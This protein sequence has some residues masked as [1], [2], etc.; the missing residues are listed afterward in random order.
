MTEEQKIPYKESALEDKSRFERDMEGY[1]A[2]EASS[3]SESDNG[4]RRRRRKKDPNEPKRALSAYLF[5]GQEKR[6][7]VKQANP[8]AKQ[9]EIIRIL[10]AMWRNLSDEDKIPFNEKAA[11]DK[12]R[13]ARQKAQYDQEKQAKADPYDSESEGSSDEMSSEE[14]E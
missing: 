6:E 3:E 9:P 1:D 14:E 8:E 5:F 11:L 2:P 12:Q 10:G 4:R 7:E 13:Y